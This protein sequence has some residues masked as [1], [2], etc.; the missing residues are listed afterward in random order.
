MSLELPKPIADY[1]EANAR[2]DLDGMLKPFLD[3]AVFIDNGKSFEGQAAIR[4]LLEAEVIPVKAI[5]TPDSV[6][7][8]AG[9]VVVEG[10]AY[11]DFPGSPLRFTYRFTLE[12]GGIKTLKVTL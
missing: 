12:S 3:D 11:G 9:D 2:L 10:P 1:V 4:H 8:D 5:F 7:K 6:H